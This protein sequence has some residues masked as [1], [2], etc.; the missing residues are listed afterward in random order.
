MTFNASAFY[1]EVKNL[2]LNIQQAV[3]DANGNVVTSASGQSD[4]R[5]AGLEFETAA[6]VT[7]NWHVG[8]SLALLRSEYTNFAYQV[9]TVNLDASGNDFYRSPDVQFRLDTSYS[10][11]LRG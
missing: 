4:G 9:G 3:T 1:Y 7:S 11:G 10:L 6:Q 2:Q 5:V 8:S